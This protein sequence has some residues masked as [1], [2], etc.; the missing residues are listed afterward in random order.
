M[1]DEALTGPLT[2][3]RSARAAQFFA[4]GLAH[5]GDSF[6]WAG[7]MVAAWF[8]GD[9]RWKTRA[10]VTFA[11][12][13][14]AEVVVI[15]MKMAIRRKRPPGESGMIYRKADPFSFPSGHA[16]RAALL[17]LL[18]WHLGPLPAFI[19]IVAWSPVMVLSR[20]AIGIHYVI[21]V[22]AGVLVGCVLTAVVL[23]AASAVAAR[24]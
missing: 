20:V 13:A 19:G 10:V 11:G 16:A 21:D 1:I 15:G 3:P 23:A 22:I 6:I 7:L 14:L 17:C 8:L 4:L 9:E 18:A 2:L 24:M 12:L 5:S